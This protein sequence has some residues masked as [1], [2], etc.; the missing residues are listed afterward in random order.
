MS[1]NISPSFTLSPPTEA[2]IPSYIKYLN[3]PFIYAGTL[4]IPKK[5]TEQDAR[6][7]IAYTE[8]K[9]QEYGRYLNFVIRDKKNSVMGGIGLHGFYGPGSHREEVGYW[10]A[11]PFR[12]KGIMSEVLEK[13]SEYARKEWGYVRLEA[14]IFDGNIPSQRVAEKS[15]YVSEGLIKKA[16]F[17]DG[18]YIDGMMFARVRD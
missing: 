2:D 3:D 5:Y 7:F 18:K 11:A 16:Y 10:M 14:P 17:K 9:Q 12:G 4:R 6:D 8:K 13:F 1:I 15:G